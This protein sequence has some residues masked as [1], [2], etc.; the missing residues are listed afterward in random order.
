VQRGFGRLTIVGWQD[1]L[2]WRK[3]WS[4]YRNLFIGQN[5][6][7]TST[8]ILDLALLVAF[9]SQPLGRKAYTP[10]FLLSIALVIHLDVL[11]VCISFHQERK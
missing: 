3:L 4:F 7:K 5:F 2:E 11:H 6:D 9:P 1:I 10:L 8:S